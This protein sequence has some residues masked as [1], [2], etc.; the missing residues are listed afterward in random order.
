MV[1]I[2]VRSLLYIYIHVVNLK[3]ARVTI[4]KKGGLFTINYGPLLVCQ[5]NFKVT[6]TF[7]F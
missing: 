2:T 1:M 4:S 7:F 5:L 3:D 6:F